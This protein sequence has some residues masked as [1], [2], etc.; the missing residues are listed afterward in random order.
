MKAKVKAHVKNFLAVVTAHNSGKVPQNYKQKHA[1]I[2]DKTSKDLYW[3]DCF[4]LSSYFSLL[5]LYMYIHIYTHICIILY[6]L[7]F[8]FAFVVRKMFWYSLRFLLSLKKAWRNRSAYSL[9]NSIMSEYYA[10]P[11]A[12]Q[13]L[14]NFLCFHWRL[15][16]I[17]NIFSA[18]INYV[19]F[20]H[21][22]SLC[23]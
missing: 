1:N 7:S 23:L 22:F 9:Y 14:I 10:R 19:F 11:A 18:W 17:Y 15:I 21:R 2:Y 13:T 20:L 5:L 6:L 3:L 16:S 12:I 4:Q 8:L